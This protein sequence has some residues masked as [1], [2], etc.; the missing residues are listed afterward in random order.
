MKRAVRRTD[1]GAS[2]LWDVDLEDRDIQ[3]PRQPLFQGPPLNFN[4]ADM[5][6]DARW[7]FGQ[8]PPPPEFD[9]QPKQA[10]AAKEP[11]APESAVPLDQRAPEASALPPWRYTATAKPP[12]HDWRKQS[13]ENGAPYTKTNRWKRDHNRKYDMWK[14]PTPHV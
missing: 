5:P 11:G 12:W 1:F 2:L 13:P 8:V 14:D 9:D 3:K 7:S 6:D 4:I 10:E